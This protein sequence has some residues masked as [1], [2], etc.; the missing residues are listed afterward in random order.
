MPVAREYPDAPRAAVGAIVLDAD[1]VLLVRRGQPPGL[2][3]W[4]VPGGLLDLGERL[5]DAVVREVE[6]ESGLRVQVLGLCGVLDRIIP[7]DRTDDRGDPI[8]RYHWVI[9]DYV[10]TVVGGA[11]CAGSDAAEARWVPLAELDRYDMTEGL[12][13]MIKRAVG[14]RQTFARHAKG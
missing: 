4:S 11:L 12:V 13:Q 7:G 2:G 1:N 5:E 9:V 3:K 14:L 8:V 10:A 6:E